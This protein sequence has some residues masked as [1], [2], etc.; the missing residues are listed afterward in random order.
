[1]T[2]QERDGQLRVLA[3]TSTERSS[4]R[5]D[6][7]GTRESGLPDSDLGPWVSIWGPG[8]MLPAIVDRLGT[9]I[10]KVWDNPDQAK[11][12]NSLSVDFRCHPSDFRC[13]CMGSG[14]VGARDRSL[15]D[16]A[17]VTRLLR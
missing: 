1:L 16:R 11:A 7:P 13:L 10:Q 12:L 17:A 15:E 4:L 2:Q 14:K 6:L 9:T 5:P 3:V 8:R